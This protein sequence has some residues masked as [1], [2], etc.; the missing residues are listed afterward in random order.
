[1]YFN[2]ARFVFTVLFSDLHE[3]SDVYYNF[4]KPAKGKRFFSLNM[5][6]WACV[7]KI[8]QHGHIFGLALKDSR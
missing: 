7:E 2:R 5:N 3:K 8:K 6:S 4:Q 1:M